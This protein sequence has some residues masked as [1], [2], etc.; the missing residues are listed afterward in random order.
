MTKDY[1]LFNEIINELIAQEIT[2][3]MHGDGIYL[4]N[5]KDDAKIKG[6]TSYESSIS[7]VKEFFNTYKKE[8]IE[9]RR[10][11]NIQIIFDKV[12]KENFDRL[13]ELFHKFYESFSGWE[14]YNLSTDI[15]NKKNT[16]RVRIY[17]DIINTR[18][19]I[20]KDMKIYSE[21]NLNVNT[22]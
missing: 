22:I 5:T 2:I 9:S 18:D 21:K 19:E 17:V 11:N 6:G 20:L 14:F 13:N 16:E 12:G 8:I 15:N 1:E 4:L 7:L 10:N 3:Q